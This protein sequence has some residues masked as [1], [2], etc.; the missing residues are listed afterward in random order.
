MK[1]AIWIAALL[2]SND[3]AA[4]VTV[5]RIGGRGGDSWP[6]WTS[7]NIVTDEETTQGVIQ[8]FELD[9]EKNVLLRLKPWA[10]WRRPRLAEWRPGSPRI[11]RGNATTSFATDWDPRLVLDGDPSTGFGVKNYGGYLDREF[12]TLDLGVHL[13][14][15][16]FRFVPQEA[17]DELSGE[18]YRPGWAL[19]NFEVSGGHSVAELL[20]VEG[21]YHPLEILL[22]RVENN[23]EF[24]AEVSFPLQYLRVVRHKALGEDL[25]SATINIAKYAI[26]ELELYGRGFAPEAIWESKPVDLGAMGIVGRVEFAVSK[27]RRQGDL[28]VEAPAARAA[29][30]IDLQTGLDDTPRAFYTY[31]QMGRLVET[32]QEIYANRLKN[33]VRSWDPQG[34]GWRGPIADDTEHWSFWSAPLGRSG[35][36]PRLP[37]GR[38]AKVRVRLETESLWEYA[39][40]ESL[41]IVTSPLLAERV[42]GE[43]AVSGDLQPS[44]SIAQVPAGEPTHMVYDM[45][46]EFAHAEQAGFNAVRISVPGEARFLELDMGEPLVPVIPDS[47]VHEALG[48]TVYLP[49]PIEADGDRHLRLRLVTTIYDAAA[50]IG[51]EAFDRDGDFL[52]QSVEP[53]DASAEIGTNQLLVLSTD[54]GDLLAGV[55]VEPGTV[56]PQGD[57]VNDQVKVA[58]NLFSVRS[59]HVEVAVY[60]LGGILVRQLLGGPQSA[61]EHTQTW[62]GRDDQG[63]LLAPGMYL[64]RVEVEADEGRIARLHPVS[65]AY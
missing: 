35:E 23:F 46:A 59:A 49:R 4:E 65:V 17:V 31:D 37:R 18:P 51:A 14:L 8:P 52:P 28:L 55:T 36:R 2:V 22:A 3:A 62:D 45:L 19:R 32:S 43:V 40:V 60:T 13:P 24:E 42:N 16:R 7:F 64:L 38:Y 57:G 6:D 30:E 11:W 53:G 29:A 9:P 5:W 58:Y 48:F 61:G 41:S 15:E 44:G 10:R 20:V 33:I 26:G 25:A 21:D 12:Y 34:M 63:E 56:T 39:R 27:W 1:W 50:E 54:I 47:V